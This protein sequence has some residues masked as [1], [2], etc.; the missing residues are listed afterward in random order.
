MFHVLKAD[1]P[2]KDEQLWN[3]AAVV[4]TPVNIGASVAVTLRFEHP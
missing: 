4:V 3:I 1:V 2:T